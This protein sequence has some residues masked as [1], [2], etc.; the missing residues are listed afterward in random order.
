MRIIETLNTT[1]PTVQVSR[2]SIWVPD[3]EVKVPFQFHSKICKYTHPGEARYTLD[4][5]RDEIA[6]LRALAALDMAPPIG[7]LVYIKNVISAYG[8][9]LRFD[10]IGAWGYEMADATKLP[11]GK[12]DMSRMLKLPIDG[13]L[14]AW[15]DVEKPGNVINGYLVDV[16]RSG[17]DLLEWLG[18]REPLPSTPLDADLDARVRRDCQFPLGER[19]EPYQDFWLTDRQSWGVAEGWV[20]GSRRV[21][22]RAQAL[23]FNPGPGESVV[24][25]GCQT[26]GF[27]QYAY[28]CQQVDA[29]TLIGIDFQPEYIRA[30][31][32]LARASRMGIDYRQMDVT[33]QPEV[34]IHWI[35]QV[36]GGA[37][38]HLL[39][40]SMEK[41]IGHDVL[42]HLVDDIRA[43]NTYI[44]TNAY[45][46]GS[47]SKAMVDAAVE[48]R[49]GQYLRDSHDRNP[50]RLYKIER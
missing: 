6:I 7:E 36:C 24:D 1:L 30:C 14:G 47:Q 26:G 34:A 17:H 11:P 10:P 20:P 50:R 39:L 18:A 15:S 2:H 3:Q 4:S 23:G 32:D 5:L 19:P 25:I 46:A 43:K 9:V 16:R 37:P 44:E 8:G 41:H 21:V 48:A 49:S 40:L 42:W 33:R 38:D 22:D 45:P 31:R 35:R 28:L 29:G 12:F 13:S 27:L